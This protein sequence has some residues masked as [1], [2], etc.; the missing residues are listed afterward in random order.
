MLQFQ[1]GEGFSDIFKGLFPRRLDQ[2]AV[3]PDEG[4]L[5]AVRMRGGV[6]PEKAPRT[7]VA[8][9]AAGS[10]GGHHLDQLVFLGLNR[11]LAAVAAVGADRVGA[12]EH[13]WSELVHGQAA[14]DGPNRADLDASAAE[15][16]V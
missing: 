15:L 8:V 3:A 5:K 13:P 1:A 9:V 14:G 10:V 2:L 6:V 16:A 11:D 12:L 7:E 4:M